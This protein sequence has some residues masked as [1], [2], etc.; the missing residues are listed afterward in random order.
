MTFNDSSRVLARLLGDEVDNRSRA[1]LVSERKMRRLAEE[2][3]FWSVRD[4][5]VATY[6][7]GSRHRH[8][9]MFAGAADLQGMD[10]YV[11]GC[12]P[13]VT[14]PGR[15]PP[16]RAAYDYLRATQ[17]NHRPLPTWLYTQGLGSWLAQPT[18]SEY[19]VQ[20]LSVLAAGAKG[21]MTFQTGIALA[22]AAPD[23]WDEM[24][25]IS[26]D[27]GAL[28]GLLREGAPTGMARVTRGRAIV[29]AIRVRGGLVLVIIGL[30]TTQGPTDL[31]C[32]LQRHRPWRLATQVV[33]VSVDLPPDLGVTDVFEVRDGAVHAVTLPMSRAGRTV[34]LAG[35]PLD[36]SI[37]GRIFVLAGA[38]GI[39]AAV[40][41]RLGGSP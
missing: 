14:D 3:T 8:A 12:A 31:L 7:G 15:H 21:L 20:A 27:V 1:E 38:A 22:A 26:R 11:A 18:A 37:A 4:P 39:R 29:E 35:M 19:R 13:H 10:M 2:A 5:G 16:L 32:L 25:K 40:A 33:D 28:R 36:D 30:E 34:R 17:R 41:S 24:G 9:G 6:I 23:T